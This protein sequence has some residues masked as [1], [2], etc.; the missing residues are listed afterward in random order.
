MNTGNVIL[1]SVLPVAQMVLM[2]G[3]GALAVRKVRSYDFL[4]W[5]HEQM[6]AS[7]WAKHRAKN[8]HKI[9]KDNFNYVKLTSGIEGERRVF[10]SLNCPNLCRV[11]LV[12][13]RN[14]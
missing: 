14:S 13:F 12:C 2:C 5:H 8:N 3:A 6:S 4:T 1:S 10:T 7:V 11:L 9:T